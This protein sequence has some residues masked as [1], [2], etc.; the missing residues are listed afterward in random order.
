MLIS[1]VIPHHKEPLSLMTPLLSSLDTQIGIDYNEVEFLI[2]NDDKECIIGDFSKFENI[3][4]RIRNLFNEKTGY[5]G[6]SRQIGVDNAKGDYILFF[7]AD[8][9]CY[10]CTILFDLMSRCCHKDADIYGY[11]FIE[12]TKDG[13]G[14]SFFIPHDFGWIWT[15]AK[16]YSREFLQKH[17]IRFSNTLLWHEDTFF[18]QTIVA[19]NP[20]VQV[21]DYVGY[22]WRYNPASITRRNNAEYS[23]KSLCMYIDS[24]DEVIERTKYLVT[25]QQ[26]TEK[27]IWL[28]AYIYCCLQE[29]TQQEIRNQARPSIEKRLAEF[30]KKYD[31]ALDCI[32]TEYMQV[33]SDT[34]HTNT[35]I[36]IPN[37][38]FETFVKRITK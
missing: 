38:G 19:Y 13:K 26:I 2:V 11:K 27:K 5:M 12:E 3:A 4:P 20:R 6:V 9:L 32:K 24:I 18:N 15:F 29:L 25:G 17:N 35:S 16:L 21:L 34:I 28:I 33:V 31:P 36:L 22:V 23:S 30:I 10:S 8:D 37:E 1:V 7:D 14:N